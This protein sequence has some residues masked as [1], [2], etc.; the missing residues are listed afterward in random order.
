MITT[1]INIKPHL[2]E[3]MYGKY[4]NCDDESPI[5]LSEKDDLY[6]MMWQLMRKRPKNANPVDSGNLWLVLSEKHIG[7][8]PNVY[9]YI[10]ACCAELIE[11]KIEALFF[12]EL[13]QRTEENR[14][15]G[16]PITT[17]KVVYMFLCEYGIESITEDALIKNDYRW[18]AKVRRK[19]K[20]R[21]YNSSR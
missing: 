14:M 21:A 16:Y 15:D 20:K 18:Q 11:C 9:N 3:Y 8:D 5:N 1:K 17:Q 12:L 7:K 13:H 10:D 4:N 6:H 19:K 2:A